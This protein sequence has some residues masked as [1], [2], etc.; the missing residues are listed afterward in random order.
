MADMSV[1]SNRFTDTG[2]GKVAGDLSPTTTDFSPTT[3]EGLSSTKG[4]DVADSESRDFVLVES[5]SGL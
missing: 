1:C 5:V 3:L 2:V 4:G